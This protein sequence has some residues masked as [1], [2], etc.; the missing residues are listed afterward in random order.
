MRIAVVYFPA[1]GENRLKALAQ[2]VAAGV[3]EQG[4][5]VH[6]IDGTKEYEKK[7]TVYEYLCIGTEPVS[8]LSGK[9]PE[10]ISTYLSTSGVV[11]GKRCF[12]FV[13]KRGLATGRSLSRLMARMEGEGMFLKYSEVLSSPEQAKEI[14]RRLRIS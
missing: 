5:T 8:F 7:L 4:H 10:S 11:A 13:A 3:E 2:A 6:I 14:S 9:V 12:A 1:A